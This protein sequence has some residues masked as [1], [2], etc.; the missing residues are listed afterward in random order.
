MPVSDQKSQDVQIH[1]PDGLIIGSV[2]ILAIHA[3]KKFFVTFCSPH[4]F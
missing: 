4:S 1:A 2:K 3:G